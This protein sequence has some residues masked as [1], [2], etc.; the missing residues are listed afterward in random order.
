MVSEWAKR[1]KEHLIPIFKE[2]ERKEYFLDKNDG[3]ATQKKV[4]TLNQ[5]LADSEKVQF[6]FSGLTTPEDLRELWGQEAAQVAQVE[7]AKIS[8]S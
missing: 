8:I 1:R 4:Y 2:L 3:Q 6:G 7:S 5:E